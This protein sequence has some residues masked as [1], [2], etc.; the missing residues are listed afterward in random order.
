MNELYELKHRLDLLVCQDPEDTGVQCYECPNGA[1]CVYLGDEIKKR[2]NMTD[3][4]EELQVDF[5][6]SYKTFREACSDVCKQVDL[7]NATYEKRQRAYAIVIICLASA[8]GIDLI[9]LGVLL[10]SLLV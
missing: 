2:E 7:D 6:Y 5:E 8:L 3:Q 10:G 9:V 4:I 1:E